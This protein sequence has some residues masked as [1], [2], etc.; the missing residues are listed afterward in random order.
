MNSK[1]F[2]ALA[3]PAVRDDVGRH[4]RAE[5]AV[6]LVDVLDH[7]LAPIAAREI[8]IDVGPLAALF[9]EEPLEEQVHA[10][11]IDGRDAEAVADGAVGGR[12]AALHEDVVLPAEVDEVPDDQ[13]IAGEIELLDQIELARDLR[14]GAVV[15]RPVPLARPHL[16]DL[17]QERHH[18]LARR[19][20]VLG[21]AIAEIRHRV[22]E[23]IGQP[24]RGGKGLRA[25]GEEGGH[26][27]RRFQVPLRVRREAAAGGRKRDAVPDAREHVEERALRRGR[28]PHAVGRDE[29]HVIR[30]REIHE[31]VVVGVLVAEPMTLQ[32]HV[33]AVAAED[34]D[35]PIEQAAD[36]VA[37]RAK[38]LA[39]GERHE[40]PHLAVEL[41]ERERAFAFRRAELHPR[42]ETAQVPIPLGG[43]DEDRKNPARLLASPSGLRVPVS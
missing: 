2:I 24:A 38:D 6:A 21:E 27:R 16:R 34:P 30:R 7:P 4:A 12:A 5:L 41:L 18:R 20:G 15:V 11:R 33:D 1:W 32:L 35:E 23:S 19:H 22:R 40:A 43:F 14:P 13:E 8:E 25:I 36:A 28:E 3:A 17:P 26:L 42:H 39:A 9:G 10:D 29:R 31:G 37:T